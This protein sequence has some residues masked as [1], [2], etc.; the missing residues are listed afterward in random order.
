MSEI[1]LVETGALRK[2]SAELL[3]GQGAGAALTVMDDTRGSRQVITITGRRGPIAVA[4]SWRASVA[5][6]ARFLSSSGSRLDMSYSP[7]DRNV[8]TSFRVAAPYQM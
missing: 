5:A 6:N 4:S 2:R 1:Q 3:V 7:R 8:D